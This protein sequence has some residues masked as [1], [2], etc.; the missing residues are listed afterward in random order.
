MTEAV[1]LLT[2]FAGQELARL[3]AAFSRVRDIRVVSTREQ[4]DGVRLGP[5]VLLLSF[6]TGLIIP[7]EKLS[8][9]GRPAYNLH[10]ASPSFPGRDPHH[11][12]VY[13]GAETYGATLHI[14]TA[15][16]DAGPIVAVETFPVSPDATPQSLLTAANEAG[17]RLV[18]RCA[19]DLLGL[20][21]MPSLAGVIWGP[22]KTRRSDLISLSRISPLIGEAEFQRRLRAFDGGQ[23]NNLVVQLHD[24]LF[25]IEKRSSTSS[26]AA[27]DGAD[28]TEQAFRALLR[29]LKAGGYRFAKYGEV[30]EDRHVIWRHDVDLSIHRAA[31]LAEIE[32]QEGIVATYFVNPR[33][34]FYNLLEPSTTAL[35]RRIMGLGH[36]IGLHFDAG[37]YD[38]GKWETDVLEEC[39]GRERHLLEFVLQTSIKAVSWH[40]PDVS[41]LLE[42]E[43]EEIAGLKNAYSRQMK[44]EYEY[45]S[46][47]NGY[48]RFKPMRAVIAERHMRLHLLS[49]PEWWTEEPL[50]PSERVDRAI[51]GRARNLRHEYDTALERAGR[52][53]VTS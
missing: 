19:A 52:L 20:Q 13:R 25:R 18:E 14:M 9:L 38:V 48:W 3:K 28:F 42:F 39:V 27:A 49:H 41:N 36:E 24:R 53:N 32:S 2:S 8:E 46:D 6:G 37:A 29:E 45:C 1:V 12:A 17:L 21:P 31:A 11:H 35:V 5:H 51:L 44:S 34:C 23:H 30:G 26:T 4:L 50:S 40:N 43:A 47:S 22:R 10:A 16:V 7:D 33:C 15:K